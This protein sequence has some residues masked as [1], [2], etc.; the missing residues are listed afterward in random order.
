MLAGALAV[1]GIESVPFDMV[2]PVAVISTIILLVPWT[3][4]RA[5][6]GAPLQTMSAAQVSAPAWLSTMV[7]VPVK[8]L[9]A[10]C[11]SRGPGA[12]TATPA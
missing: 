2:P 7:R 5:A 4:K 1:K 3:L 11:R 10:A 12:W 8:L 6:L 9:K